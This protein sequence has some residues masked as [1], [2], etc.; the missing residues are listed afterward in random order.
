MMNQRSSVVSA[1]TLALTLAGATMAGK[2]AGASPPELP[3]PKLTA[4]PVDGVKE[5]RAHAQPTLPAGATERARQDFAGRS[6]STGS[7]MA[8]KAA[9]IRSAGRGSVGASSPENS[10]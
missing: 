3:L 1:L 4:K 9:S 7:T 6:P 5:R 10:T 2:V 8:G